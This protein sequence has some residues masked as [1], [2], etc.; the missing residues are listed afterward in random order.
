MRKLTARFLPFFLILF[1]LDA[2]LYA[3]DAAAQ[4]Q[5][6]FMWKVQSKTST[7][8]VLGS[9]HFMKK[10]VYPLNN[11]I[12]DAFE[13]SNILAV[14]ANINDA[15]KLDLQKLLTSAFYQGNETLEKHVSKETYDLVKKKQGAWACP[16]S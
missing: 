4:N 15:A 3:R 11:K 1:L 9:V 13:K 2:S 8:Y 6:T 12:E 14:E 5:K 7:V 16:L 10:E